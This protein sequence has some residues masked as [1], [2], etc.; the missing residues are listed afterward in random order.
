MYTEAIIQIEAQA[1]APQIVP[2]AK[3]ARKAPWL[4]LLSQV[5]Q[6]AGNEAEFLRHAEKPWASATFSGARHTIVLA[7]EGLAASENGEVFIA[8]LP[9]HEF[10][11]PRYLVA[12]A[13]IVSVEHRQL[14]TVRLEVEFELLLLE[15][16]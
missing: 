16:C 15:H 5:L 1:P 12:D 7:F 10:S 3:P 13:A 2:R 9:E 11:F 4:R 8:A 14:P 6:L